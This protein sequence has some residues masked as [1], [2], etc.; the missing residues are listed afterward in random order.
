MDTQWKLS[1][2]KQEAFGMSYAITKWNCYLQRSDI[3]ICNDHKTLQKFLNG[4]NTNKKV[5]WWS[6]ELAIYNIPFEWI[7]NVWNKAADCLSQLVAVPNNS[8][9]A[10]ILINPVAASTTHRSA[11]P[12][13]SKIKH[14]CM[15]S[16]WCCIT[17]TTRYHQSQC[18]RTS[19][20]RPQGYPASDAENRSIL[21]ELLK[22]VAWWQSTSPWSWHFLLYEHSMDATQKF[23]ALVILKSWCFTVLIKAHDKLGHQGINMT[24]H[25]IKWQYYWKGMN[26]DA[27]GYFSFCLIS[28]NID[29][30]KNRIDIFSVETSFH[31]LSNMASSGLKKMFILQYYIHKIVY[32]KIFSK[33]TFFF[34]IMADV[35]PYV[36]L[37][38]CLGWCYCLFSLGDFVTYGQMLLPMLYFGRCYCLHQY[39]SDW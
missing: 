13:Y 17:I 12:P 23:L 38:L 32:Q 18:T 14:Q 39:N 5:N 1:T 8:V 9:A 30:L 35:M 29:F 4:K 6:L 2:P 31:Q 22:T 16:T 19:H 7:S 33:I 15:V 24:Y 36:R 37:M 34:F 11:A 20:R 25:L 21:Q 10:S 3:V 28:C 27:Y 26:K